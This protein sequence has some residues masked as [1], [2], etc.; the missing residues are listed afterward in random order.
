[1]ATIEQLQQKFG[2][3]GAVEFGLHPSGLTQATVSK[4]GHSAVVMLHGAH[5]VSYRGPDGDDILWM[6]RQSWFENGKP[7]RGGVPICFP[8]FGPK[9]DDARAPGHGFARLLEWQVALATTLDDGR[10]RL[11]LVLMDNQHTRRLWNHQFRLAFGAT[12]GGGALELRLSVA[13]TGKEPLEF[14]EALHTYV[15]VGDVRKVSIGGLERTEYVDKVS[16]PPWN[17]SGDK[18][19]M[20]TG[21][22]DRVYLNTQNE[23]ILDDPV[24]N[25]R[26][27]VAKTGSKSTVIWTPWIDKA[28]RMEDFGDDEWTSMV[29]IETANAL[30]NT[31]KVSPGAFHEMAAV[32]SSQPR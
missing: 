9:A 4:D 17:M 23:C 30:E 1:M 8:W 2:I 11:V 15:S 22:T 31:V 18:P 7:I 3:P 13:N 12:I 28:K 27:A 29:C 14:T 32:I 6:S 24:L 5:V 21:E 26:I 25:R 16:Q 19:I 10:V 20:F